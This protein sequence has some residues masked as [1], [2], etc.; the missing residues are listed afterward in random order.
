MKT[1]A[2]CLG[3]FGFFTMLNYYLILD[4]TK[5]IAC[6]EAIIQ[7]DNEQEYQYFIY[8]DEMADKGNLLG[9]ME[10]QYYIHL[11]KFY[12]NIDSK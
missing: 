3:I 12:K 2:I 1:I 9:E 10:Q 8:L 5:R 4:M 11:K 6:T 7:R